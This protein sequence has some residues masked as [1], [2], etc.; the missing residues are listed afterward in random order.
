[1]K[2]YD[3]THNVNSSSR[4]QGCSYHPTHVHLRRLWG[5]NVRF[6]NLTN[7]LLYA[8][9][10]HHLITDQASIQMLSPPG[11]C[12]LGPT[13]KDRGHRAQPCWPRPPRCSGAAQCLRT[14]RGTWRL[15]LATRQSKDIHSKNNTWTAPHSFSLCVFWGMQ[16]HRWFCSV[17]AVSSVFLWICMTDQ[18]MK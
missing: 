3:F 1:M 14:G 15:D 16:L 12:S 5:R 10:R 2:N 7:I 11:P 4:C 8:T 17:T 18:G 9:N 6:I 13:R